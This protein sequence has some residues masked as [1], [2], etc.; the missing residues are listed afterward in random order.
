MYLG[1]PR[2]GKLRAAVSSVEQQRHDCHSGGVVD[3]AALG[4][5]TAC[6]HSLPSSFLEKN[7]GFC[8][9]FQPASKTP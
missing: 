3:R 9:P 1:L 5:Q 7:P 4:R 2:L 6:A 8:H